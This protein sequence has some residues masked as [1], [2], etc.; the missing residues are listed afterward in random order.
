MVVVERI[1]NDSLCEGNNLLMKATLLGFGEMN[2]T[3]QWQYDAGEGWTD[4]EGADSLELRVPADSRNMQCRWRIRVA[5][6]PEM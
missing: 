2:Y 6:I 4:V 3:A 1:M 5:L